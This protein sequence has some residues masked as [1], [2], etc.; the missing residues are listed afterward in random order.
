MPVRPSA[1]RAASPRR[2]PA[3]L[4]RWELRATPSTLRVAA[5]AAAA[6]SSTSAPPAGPVLRTIADGGVDPSVSGSVSAL[7]VIAVA[8]ADGIV[9][10]SVP[11]RDGDGDG[12]RGRA[13]SGD[14]DRTVA[15]LIRVRDSISDRFA[16]RLA[17][18]RARDSVS[19]GTSITTADSSDERTCRCGGRDLPHFRPRLR[20]S[21]RSIARF[22]GASMPHKGMRYLQNSPAKQV[23]A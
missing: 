14:D 12:D 20:G 19:A 4:L 8:D 10:H 3:S 17:A 7:V 11:V 13:E 9:D 6:S 22:H 15:V 2:G 18:C 21:C 16:A 5:V 1:T 23:P